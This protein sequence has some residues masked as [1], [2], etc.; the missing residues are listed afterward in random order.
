[1]KKQ[2]NKQ[3]FWQQILSM[4][5]MVIFILLAA[6]SDENTTKEAAELFLIIF[7]HDCSQN[8]DDTMTDSRYF[9]DLEVTIT[10]LQCGRYHFWCGEVTIQFRKKGSHD[11]HYTEVVN[12]KDGKR[13]GLST[14]TTLDGTKHYYQYDMGHRVDMEK[15]T[16]NNQNSGISAY[17]ILLYKYPW[18]AFSLNALGFDNEYIE[19]YLDTL[20]TV[21]YSY[22]FGETEF[23]DYYEESVEALEETYYDSIISANSAL[24]FLQGMEELKNAEFRLAVID[25][26]YTESTTYDIVEQTYPNYLLSLKEAEITD[27]DFE[28]FCNDLDDSLTSYGPLDAEDLYFIDSVDMFLYRALFSIAFTEDTSSSSAK[29]LMKSTALAYANDN[30]SSLYRAVYPVLKPLLMQSGSSEVGM[31][32]LYSM[33]M[34]F[35]QGDIMQQAVKEAWLDRKGISRI[36]TVITCFSEA[37]SPTSV[38]LLGDV[39]EDGGAEITER[40]IAWAAFF[41]PTIDNN[42]VASG[43]GTGEFTIT[44]SDLTEGTTYYARSYAK[45]SAGTAYGNCI[46]FVASKSS[47]INE[48]EMV[49]YDFTV[50]PNPA[51]TWAT[52]SF[53]LKSSENVLLTI[54]DMKGRQVFNKEYG[55]MSQGEHRIQVDLS[56]LNVG[57]YICHL[58]D[59]TIKASHKLVVAR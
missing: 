2:L 15:A 42:V 49:N 6:G 50:Y 31:V 39:I 20:E 8:Y 55:I 17:Q 52:F 21:L 57:M 58:S 28:T 35:I 54:A 33:M 38:T 5:V 29:H 3:T 13:H 23:S 51:S 47:G 40:G 22:D 45:N 48:N 37:V 24:I 27:Q 1:M 19:A 18:Y 12:M 41:N 46:S 53:Q 32:V 43:T 11:Y 56:C 7:D 10:G 9:G 16:H 59:G 25:R 30:Q 44:L 14:V 4:I 34:C 26:Y 36:P